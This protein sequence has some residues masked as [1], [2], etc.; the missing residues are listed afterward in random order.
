[1]KTKIIFLI[2]LLNFIFQSTIFQFFRIS[3]IL[4]NTGLILVVAIS[5]LY[6]RETGLSTGFL[7]GVLQDI[8]FSKAIGI[9]ILIYLL[10]AYTIGGLRRKLFKD[11]YLTPAILIVLATFFYHLSYFIIMYFLKNSISFSLIFKDILPIESLLNIVI[12]LLIY[13]KF[14]EYKYDRRLI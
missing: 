12:G 7:T 11:N 8:F 10:I 1:M 5:I 2:V 9:N 6:G 3:G 14:Y 13:K 4:A